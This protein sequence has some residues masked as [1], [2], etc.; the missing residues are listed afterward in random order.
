MVKDMDIECDSVIRLLPKRV[1]YG[2]LCEYLFDA[3]ELSEVRDAVV[4]TMGV[5]GGSFGR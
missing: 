1:Y 5:D 2:N 3:A 4:E